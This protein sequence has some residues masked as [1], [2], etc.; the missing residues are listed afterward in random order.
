MVAVLLALSRSSSPSS[1]TVGRLLTPGRI[2]ASGGPGGGS[3]N[4]NLFKGSG[5]P[6]SPDTEEQKIGMS[7]WKFDFRAL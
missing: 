5:E 1:W 4:L 3:L 2:L 7:A 6:T